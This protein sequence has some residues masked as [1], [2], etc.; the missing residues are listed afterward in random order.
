MLTPFRVG[1]ASMLNVR[2]APV[3]TLF[4]LLP[5]RLPRGR[6]AVLPLALAS[7]AALT[8]DVV[9]ATEMRRAS[10]AIVGDDYDALLAHMK[11]SSRL[12]TLGFDQRVPGMHYWSY[13]FAGSYHRARGGAVASWSFTELPHW[14]VHYAPGRAPPEHFPFWLFQPCDFRHGRDGRYYDYVLV[15]GEAPD[16]LFEARDG[17]QFRPVARSG[18]MTL[19]QKTE[20]PSAS[21][22]ASDDPRLCDR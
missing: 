5:L 16:A 10:R 2:L 13:L 4:A 17:V 1:A 11:P 6:K 7:V 14:P 22:A 9:A 19:L 15:R 18:V 20:V 12:V 21:S 8:A 3:V